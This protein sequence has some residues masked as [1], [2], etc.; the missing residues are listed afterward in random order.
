MALPNITVLKRQAAL[1]D[2]PWQ[3]QCFL[4]PPLHKQNSLL[5]QVQCKAS[6]SLHRSSCCLPS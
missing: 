5:P 3:L 1:R 6:L 2:T 4:P